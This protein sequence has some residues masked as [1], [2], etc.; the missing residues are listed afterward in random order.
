M[1]ISPLQEIDNVPSLG[2]M[3]GSVRTTDVLDQINAKWGSN[4]V[5]FGMPDNPFQEHYKHFMNLV[6]HQLNTTD[7][8]VL[9]T[10]EA[11]MNPNRFKVIQ[12]ETDLALTPPCMM[13]PL[14]TM[15]Q[16]YELAI[17]GKIWAWGYDPATLPSDDPYGRIL[18]NGKVEWDPRDPS[19]LP[20][21]IT[22]E[23]R[24]DDPDLTDEQWEA[25]EKSRKWLADWIEN[26]MDG[27]ERR[28]PTDLSNV[29]SV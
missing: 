14:L 15:P 29:I 23:W 4:T 13:V 1:H 18:N 25:I 26:E 11:V 17:E 19:T 6:N 12:N 20:E 7:Q 24:S 3:I 10:V 28:D 16:M 22:W 2:A 9:S 5:A 21:Y 27:G 8:L